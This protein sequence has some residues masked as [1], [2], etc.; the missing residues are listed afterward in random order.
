MRRGGAVKRVLM[1]CFIALVICQTGEKGFAQQTPTRIAGEIPFVTRITPDA[2]PPDAVVQI[3]IQGSSVDLEAIQKY[4]LTIG[5][6]TAQFYKVSPNDNSTIA[7]VVPKPLIGTG[8]A[9]S[10]VPVEVIFYA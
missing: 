2:A 9:G 10:L 5:G 8:P 7:A 6:T 4:R 3:S 1:I